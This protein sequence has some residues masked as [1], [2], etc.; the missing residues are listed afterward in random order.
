M[1]SEEKRARLIQAGRWLRE[2]RERRGI[3][4]QAELARRLGWDKSLISNYESGKTE[5]PD[6]RAED[7]AEFLGIDII[8]FR[9]KFGLWVAPRRSSM[10]EVEA[11]LDDSER[12]AA[13][14]R[15]LD[16]PDRQAIEI[17]IERLKK[18]SETPNG[19]GKNRR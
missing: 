16:E 17:L 11:T 13:E 9:S 4:S 6:D 19:V 8:T 12:L 18:A 3:T 2:Q 1:A 15:A 7:L 10:D 14:L 5:I